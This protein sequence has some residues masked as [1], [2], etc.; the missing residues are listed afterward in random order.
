MYLVQAERKHNTATLKLQF[1]GDLRGYTS[2]QSRNN[3]GH[4]F[5][6]ICIGPLN[7]NVCLHCV[8]MFVCQVYNVCNVQGGSLCMT[9]CTFHHI[10]I[11]FKFN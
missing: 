6:Y 8:N 5:A 2:V 7:V 11:C 3:G 4:C 9:V 1:E 10:A